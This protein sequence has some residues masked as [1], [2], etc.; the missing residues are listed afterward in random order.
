MKQ[1]RL[2]TPANTPQR[3]SIIQDSF[4]EC[5]LDLERESENEHDDSIMSGP[6][7]E[8]LVV[9][10]KSSRK[11]K[12]ASSSSNLQ[13]HCRP[14][15]V[16]ASTQTSPVSEARQAS[17]YSQERFRLQQEKYE[18]RIAFDSARMK[19]KENEA[20]R[21]EQQLNALRYAL[22]AKDRGNDLI[23]QLASSRTNVKTLENTLAD[24]RL[25]QPF[26]RLASNEP[27]LCD[28]GF[29][30]TKMDL[31]GRD[32]NSLARLDG[33]QA[34]DFSAFAETPETAQLV[35]RAFPGFDTSGGSTC[36]TDKAPIELKLNDFIRTL[37][38]AALCCWVFEF[39]LKFLHTNSPCGLCSQYRT[40]LEIQG[41]LNSITS[42]RKL[43]RVQTVRRHCE[44]LILQRTH[45]SWTKQCSKGTEFVQKLNA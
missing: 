44:T 19:D 6:N 36:L 15:T 1:E 14:G 16:D 23:K 31:I 20:K 8:S 45:A 22:Q 4:S 42:F 13:S 5:A 11:I 34:F 17:D 28:Y 35:L 33:S 41:M 26:S 40:C 43:T 10:L 24:R 9:S 39:P 25:L 2:D 29:V 32:I 37:V 27:V 12:S 7:Q 38:G 3:Q 18:S 30:G 21:Y